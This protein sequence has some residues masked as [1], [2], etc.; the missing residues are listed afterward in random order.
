[1]QDYT[2]KG[3][4]YLTTPVTYITARTTSQLS[5]TLKTKRDDKKAAKLDRGVR[6]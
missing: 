4:Q 1:M 5:T 3:D 2:S 6:F